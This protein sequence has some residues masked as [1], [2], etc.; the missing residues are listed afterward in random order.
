MLPIFG[1]TMSGT[2]QFGVQITP[3]LSL[4]TPEKA[5]MSLQCQQNTPSK[6][7]GSQSY[8]DQGQDDTHVLSKSYC[9]RA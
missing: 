9:N 6:S 1:R 3:N 5:T 7:Q 4:M 8:E 2:P